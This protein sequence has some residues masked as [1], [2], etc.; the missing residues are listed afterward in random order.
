E[1]GIRD[2]HVTGVQTCALPIYCE[3]E[4]GE[5]G[6]GEEADAL[7]RRRGDVGCGEV[8]GIVGELGKKRR[9]RGP[10][11]GGADACEDGESVDE[12]LEIGRAACRERVGSGGGEG[13]V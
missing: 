5:G 12:V 13:Y 3:Q 11:R 6:A 4:P 9:L 8:S 2:F 10:E 1:D 7:D